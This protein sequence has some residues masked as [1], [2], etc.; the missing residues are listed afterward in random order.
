MIYTIFQYTV[1]PDRVD[2][3]LEAIDS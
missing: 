2:I 1:K 3:V